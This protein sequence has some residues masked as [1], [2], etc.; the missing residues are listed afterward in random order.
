MDILK[1]DPRGKYF[2]KYLFLYKE[3]KQSKDYGGPKE[4]E[5]M[6]GKQLFVLP[7]RRIATEQQ[8][9]ELLSKASS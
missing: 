1:Y 4:Y 2:G 8:I 9:K 3:K 5:Y 6:D 7:G